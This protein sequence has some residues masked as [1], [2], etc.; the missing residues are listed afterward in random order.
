ME[1]PKDDAD[2]ERRKEITDLIRKLV[3]IE[4]NFMKKPYKILLRELRKKDDFNV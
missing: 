1:L 4:L 2:I 3:K